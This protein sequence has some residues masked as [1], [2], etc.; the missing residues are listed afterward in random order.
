MLVIP[1]PWILRTILNHLQQCHLGVRL[2]LCIFEIVAPFRILDM[3]EVHQW[4]KMNFSS[5]IPCFGNHFIFISDFRQLPCRYLLQFSYSFHIA[6]FASSILNAWGIGIILC[7]KLQRLSEFIS[8]AAMW[9]S[10]YLQ[11]T[12]SNRILI[13]SSASTIQAYFVRCFPIPR[14]LHCSDV[15]EFYKALLLASEFLTFYER[16]S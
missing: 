14:L 13:D 5:F 1:D 2:F 16:F 6:A 11:G 12:S 10:W 3:T 9:S 8:F 4:H 15:L 7:T